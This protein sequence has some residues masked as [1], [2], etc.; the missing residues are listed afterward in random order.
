MSKVLGLSLALVFALS[1]P[2]I[3]AEKLGTVKSVDRASQSFTL[4]DGTQLS[5]SDGAL[6]DLTPGQKVRAAYEVKGGKNVV[7]QL[8]RVDTPTTNFGSAIVARP[9]YLSSN[10][11]E[12]PGD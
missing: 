8:N 9:D 6:A 3:A 5:V 10:D 7:T 11:F 1:L 12:S 2:A 4:E